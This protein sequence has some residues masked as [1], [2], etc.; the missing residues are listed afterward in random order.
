M[1]NSVG[2]VGWKR[3]WWLLPR[4]NPV[5][6]TRRRAPSIELCPRERLVSERTGRWE[7]VHLHT[8]IPPL[9][10]VPYRLGDAP[11]KSRKPFDAFRLGVWSILSAGISQAIL[12][13][14]DSSYPLE[15][16]WRR[17]SIKFWEVIEF[18][19]QL[20]NISP[21]I[22]TRIGKRIAFQLILKCIETTR[23]Q[24]LC[25]WRIRFCTGQLWIHGKI[26]TIGRALE[27][28]CNPRILNVYHN[29]WTVDYY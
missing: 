18:V 27:G 26:C 12:L 3:R 7:R 10:R 4:R 2:K 5:H 24:R 1:L 28:N 22:L 6:K 13:L 14:G 8:G 19:V 17:N 25:K 16:K 23:N 29:R 20:W 21:R 15:S 9:E 11:I